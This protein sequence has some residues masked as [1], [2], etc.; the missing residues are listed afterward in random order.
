M[1]VLAACGGQPAS[2]AALQP[3]LEA[4]QTQ[5]ASQDGAQ[6]EAA[7]SV[8]EA[9][10]PAEAPS[11]TFGAATS[12]PAA[13]T[14]ASDETAATT[15]TAA[16]A[17]TAE[18]SGTAETAET[19]G[20]G[21]SDT[22]AVGGEGEFVF[23]PSDSAEASP[24]I[25][26]QLI[27]D[28]S[29]SM[30]EDIGGETKIEAARRAMENLIAQIPE[31]AGDKLN[32]GFRVFGHLGDNTDAGRAESCQSTE[33]LVPLDGVDKAALGQQALAWEPTG[34]TPISLALQKAGEDM[35]AGEN[36]R[37]VIIMVTDG[38][39]TC[40]GD[41]CAVSQALA[42][43]DTAVRIDV[44]GFGL[45]PEVADTL[46]CISDNSGGSYVDAQDGTTLEQ[47]LEDLTLNALKRSYLRIEAV[48][49]DGQLISDGTIRLI[50]A[51]TNEQGAEGLDLQGERARYIGID[52]GIDSADPLVDGYTRI[53]LEPGTYIFSVFYPANRVA[54][55]QG[56]NEA[57]YTAVIAEGQ[58][59]I[60]R[61]G[62][63]G[64][65]LEDNSGGAVDPC[66][67]VLE[68]ATENGWVNV[69]GIGRTPCANIQRVGEYG[70]TVN[71]AVGSYRLSN[72]ERGGAAT[73]FTIE[74]GKLVTIAIR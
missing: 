29:G 43:G 50:G 22:S 48:G 20:S 66:V 58:E 68:Q 59:T 12:E 19:T 47:T 56:V 61:I 3:T 49:A 74:A 4:L 16:T 54:L 44:V 1:L 52:G 9:T 23:Q 70:E 11:P 17:E 15:E 40:D 42:Q 24:T 26:V 39:E 60:A 13:T 67:L 7:P 62:I 57:T 8:P 63:G 35:Q 32:V 25:N 55:P 27:F 18:T 41:P 34:W 21:G 28:A 65:V 53:E 37:N 2:N 10:T 69:R 5:V 73:E 31:D 14:A 64:L 36:V 46:R 45:A 38:E 30:A 71:L 51:V 72:A 33:L 6:S